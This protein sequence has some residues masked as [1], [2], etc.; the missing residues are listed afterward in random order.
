MLIWE[1]YIGNKDD[2]KAQKDNLKVK[3]AH[4]ELAAA[5]EN[6]YH[7]AK[8]IRKHSRFLREYGLNLSSYYILVRMM[9]E[10]GTHKPVH[11]GSIISE[12]EMPISIG[13]RIVKSLIKLGYI[14]P[15]ESP[16]KDRYHGNAKFFGL[17]IAGA[18]LAMASLNH[19]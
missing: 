15:E 7:A 16:E 5:I 11:I 1:A 19:Y 3:F 12:M 14:I 4:N 8:V 2:L 6:H 17:T 10:N 9:E 18:R 13:S